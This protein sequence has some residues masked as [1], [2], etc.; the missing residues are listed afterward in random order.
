MNLKV[1]FK[2]KTRYTYDLYAKYN[3]FHSETNFIMNNLYNAIMVFGILFLIIMQVVHHNYEMVTLFGVLL[4]IL[5]AWRLFY[6]MFIGQREVTSDKITKEKEYTFTFYDNYFTIE[7]EN[8]IHKMKYKD[9]FRVRINHE[10]S[11]LYTDRK[12]SYILDNST[13]L[14]GSFSSFKPFLRKKVGWRYKYYNLVE[15]SLEEK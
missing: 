3:V 6:P 4:T 13:F 14:H 1:L 8:Y 7:D 12:N 9:L 10:Y 15:K 5:I 11:Y 2:N